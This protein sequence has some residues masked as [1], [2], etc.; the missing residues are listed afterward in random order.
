VKLSIETRPSDQREAVLSL[1][2]EIDYET[3][4][5][6]RTAVSSV[7]DGNIDTLVVDLAGVTFLDSTGIGTLVVAKRICHS[8][9]VKLHIRPPTRSSRAS[10]RWSASATSS[11]SRSRRAPFP[12]GSRSPA[13]AA[14]PSPPDTSKDRRTGPWAPHVQGPRCLPPLDTCLPGHQSVCCGPQRSTERSLGPFQSLPGTARIDD[15]PATFRAELAH[16]SSPHA[17]PRPS[18]AV[19]T[20]T[21][22]HPEA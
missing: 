6:L 22:I 1:S 19:L 10:S 4:Q 5:E 15:H 2:G 14:S 17:P 3:A 12:A 20:R 9:G 7:L 8:M 16:G 21:T 11:G 18:P 13:S